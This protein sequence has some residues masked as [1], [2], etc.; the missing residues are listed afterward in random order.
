MMKGYRSRSNS[1]MGQE[2]FV[3]NMLA[4]K[5]NGYCVELGSER[6]YIGNNTSLLESDFGWKGLSLD[7]NPT[8]V[9]E[10]N[11]STRKNKCIEADA[12]TFDYVKHFEDNDFPKQIDYLQV[13]IDGHEQGL[14]LLALVALPMLKYRFTVITI[15][16]DVIV[17][18]RRAGMRDAQRHLLASMGYSLAGQC[19]S[20]DWWIDES[21]KDLDQKIARISKFIGHPHMGD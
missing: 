5:K 11:A 1:D 20:E 19:P 9:T 17:D 18:F 6:P 7:I 16:H 21:S 4:E 3:L 15:E 2:A 13:D 14:C 10:F 12:L 8:M